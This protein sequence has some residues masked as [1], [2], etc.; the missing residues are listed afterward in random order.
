MI[1]RGALGDPWIFERTNAVLEGKTPPPLPPLE[2][3]LK[4]A[5]RQIELAAQDK[6]EHIAML[7][8]RKHVNWYLKGT[9]GLKM[10]KVRVSQ[11]SRLEELYELAEEIAAAAQGEWC[12]APA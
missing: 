11:L 4:T 7:E 5:V 2:K 6:G 8:A 12:Y 3:R 9:S 10:Y 1:G